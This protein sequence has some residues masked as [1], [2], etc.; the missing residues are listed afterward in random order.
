MSSPSICKGVLYFLQVVPQFVSTMTYEV[1][2][3]QYVVHDENANAVAKQ[4]NKL[5]MSQVLMYRNL[6]QFLKETQITRCNKFKKIMIRSSK[7]T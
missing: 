5:I 6:L 7:H 1:A 2:N 4:S 3:L